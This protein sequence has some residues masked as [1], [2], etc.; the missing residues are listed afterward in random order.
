MN[1][2]LTEVSM[3]GKGAVFGTVRGVK[4]S[5]FRPIEF[6]MLIR[7]PRGGTEPTSGCMTLEFR[8]KAQ[9]WHQPRD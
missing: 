1:L 8:G 7:H 4:M 9:A 3:I 5:S 2:Q 6:K